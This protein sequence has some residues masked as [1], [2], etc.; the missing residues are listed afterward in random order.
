MV[1]DRSLEVIENALFKNSAISDP[2]LAQLQS[3]PG[4]DLLLLTDVAKQLNFSHILLRC[5]ALSENFEID[6]MA[7][8][9]K[10]FFPLPGCSI[11]AEMEALG[12]LATRYR[13]NRNRY[14]KWN[15]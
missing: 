13:L 8:W 1:S 14:N 9:A 2:D 10:V 6:P 12:M 3:K 5:Y 11:F 4:P 15:T 7:D